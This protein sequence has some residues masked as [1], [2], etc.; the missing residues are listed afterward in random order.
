MKLYKFSV[1]PKN[2]KE[3]TL[4][5]QRLAE[6]NGT[7]LIGNNKTEKNI[8]L[9]SLNKAKLCRNI[10]RFEGFKV[11]NDFIKEILIEEII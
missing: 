8:Y 1:F 6:I 10:L 4:L 9:E 11:G 2:L 3:E 5:Y 7:A